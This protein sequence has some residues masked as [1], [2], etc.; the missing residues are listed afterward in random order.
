ML[1]N[2]FQRVPRKLISNIIR[3]MISPFAANSSKLFLHYINCGYDFIKE[4]QG[5]DF[6]AAM[7]KKNQICHVQIESESKKN[8]CLKLEESAISKILLEMYLVI[9]EY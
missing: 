1:G 5:K 9:F 6:A 3:L 8:R 7:R 4:I 2:F